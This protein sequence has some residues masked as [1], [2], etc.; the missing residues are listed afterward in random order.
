MLEL[1]Q[2]F[3]EQSCKMDKGHPEAILS[4]LSQPGL[5][6]TVLVVYVDEFP[7]F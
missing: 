1:L 2:P 3:C 6:T 4:A 5:K 7:L